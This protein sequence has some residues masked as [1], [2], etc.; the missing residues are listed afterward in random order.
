M[1]NTEIYLMIKNT[2][3]LQ[4][5]FIGGMGAFIKIASRFY[6]NIIFYELEICD[7]V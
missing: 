4:N 2:K 3:N 6:F 1:L 5:A 7:T